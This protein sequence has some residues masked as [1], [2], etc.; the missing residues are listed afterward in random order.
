M[1]GTMGR[2]L[3]RSVQRAC[4]IAIAL[5]VSAIAMTRSAFA[6]EGGV[7]FWLPG[8]FGSLAAAPGVPGW[9]WAT[10]YYHTSVSAGA[11]ASF[12]RGGRVDVGISGQGDLAFFGP[13]YIFA[14]PVL[15]GQFSASLLGVAGR[16]EASA[17]ISL[18][19]PRGNTLF[20]TRTQALTSI[21]DLIPML[22]LKWNQGVSNFM[23]YGTG[24]IPVGDYDPNR[25]ANLGIGHGAIDGGGGYTYFDPK[26]GH[27]FT[28][29]SGLT[30]NFKN[31]ST[32]YQN[33]IDW[34]VDWAAIR[35]E[36]GAHRSGR[37]LLPAI[38]GR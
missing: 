4:A 15:G 28:V 25:L 36:A 5:S 17:D 30:Y 18:T 22:Q 11:G 2:Q 24:D 38:D 29:A 19:G 6:D 26:T 37:L 23:V 21:G 33:G 32:D 14:Q 3:T 27:E 16:N 13:S 10:I 34:H 9:A 35:V 12:P 20:G 7:S 31:T 1:G 8:N